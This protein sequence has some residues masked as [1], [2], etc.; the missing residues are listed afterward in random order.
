M[1]GRIVHVLLALVT[2]IA[3]LVWIFRGESGLVFLVLLVA[4]ALTFLTR[5]WAP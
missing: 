3:A 2:V 4:G 5:G 1:I